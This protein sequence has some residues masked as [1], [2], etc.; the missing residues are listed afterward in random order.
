MQRGQV[1][2][3]E[4][5]KQAYQIDDPSPSKVV[6]DTDIPSNLCSVSREVDIIELSRQ[7][8]MS[9]SDKRGNNTEDE[10]EEQEEEFDD[11]VKTESDDHSPQLSY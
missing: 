3:D 5:S 8:S 10:D 1:E 6:I 9:Q 11:D 4:V 7:Y 2:V